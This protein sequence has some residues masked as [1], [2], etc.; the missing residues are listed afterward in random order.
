MTERNYA[1]KEFV[2]LVEDVYITKPGVGQVL[3]AEKGTQVQIMS[4]DPSK[5][6]EVWGV[7]RADEPYRNA[8]VK[9]TD[10]CKNQLWTTLR[11]EPVGL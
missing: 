8:P 4:Y 7:R 10:I 1:V 11:A 9:E 2:I 6:P 5:A 3:Y